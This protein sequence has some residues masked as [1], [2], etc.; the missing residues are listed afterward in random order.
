MA[1][2]S[3]V[4]TWEGAPGVG[5]PWSLQPVRAHSCSLLP[6][7]P[8]SPSGADLGVRLLHSALSKGR[9]SMKAKEEAAGESQRVSAREGR[10]HRQR[11][12]KEIG[13]EWRG[14]SNRATGPLLSHLPLVPWEGSPSY[15]LWL[16]GTLLLRILSSLC[17]WTSRLALPGSRPGAWSPFSCQADCVRSARPSSTP[18]VTAQGLGERPCIPWCGSYLEFGGPWDPNMVR[19][20]CL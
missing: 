2:P 6:C 7:P 18:S 14:A 13:T 12:N 9:I 8:T 17:N 3:C 16:S 4:L 20:V 5:T 15:N 10:P 1:V 19:G 11:R